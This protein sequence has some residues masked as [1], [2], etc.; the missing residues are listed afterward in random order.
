MASFKLRFQSS[1]G[2]T[3]GCRTCGSESTF[4]AVVRL[5]R[6]THC[7]SQFVSV[8]K[9][10]SDGCCLSHQRP[11]IQVRFGFMRRFQKIGTVVIPKSGLGFSGAPERNKTRPPEANALFASAQDWVTRT[12][13]GAPISTFGGYS[14]KVHSLRNGVPCK[15]TI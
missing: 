5:S 12:P 9:P 2:C 11:T 4:M 1:M 7:Q 6:S 13:C 14:Q 8:G 10:E 3:T 15:S